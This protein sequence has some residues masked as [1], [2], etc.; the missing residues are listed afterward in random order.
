GLRQG[1]TSP[2]MPDGGAFLVV[3]YPHLDPTVLQAAAEVAVGSNRQLVAD[4]EGLGNVDA[5]LLQGSADGICQ[6]PLIL[7]HFWPIKLTHLGTA[8]RQ[9]SAS[10]DSSHLP[11]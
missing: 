4:G 6:W 1:P 10:A 7:T 8:N 11:A 5:A 2:S 9:F 3:V